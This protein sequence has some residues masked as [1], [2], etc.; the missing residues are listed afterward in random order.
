MDCWAIMA[1]T[2]SWMSRFVTI[3]YIP[4]DAW[5]FFFLPFVFQLFF[6][7]CRQSHPPYWAWALPT[8]FISSKMTWNEKC[9][10]RNNRTIH[11]WIVWTTF[12]NHWAI[13][14]WWLSLGLWKYLYYIKMMIRIW[15]ILVSSLSLSFSSFFRVFFFLWQMFECSYVHRRWYVLSFSSFF[16]NI[17]HKKIAWVCICSYHE[18]DEKR[19]KLKNTFCFLCLETFFLW[20]VCDD[21]LGRDLP[22]QYLS[23]RELR[24]EI[25]WGL[26]HGHPMGKEVAGS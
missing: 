13:M 10:R 19:L 17:C 9:E 24:R 3:P 4:V 18:N 23:F 15:Q 20:P 25:L 21:I 26:H 6:T 8:Q 22:T 7:S 5:N 11:G 2:P 16:P 1:V 12:C 14:S